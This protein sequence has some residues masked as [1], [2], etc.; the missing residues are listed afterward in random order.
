MPFV[1]I[2]R[3]L[4]LSVRCLEFEVVSTTNQLKTLLTQL[5][6]QILPKLRLLYSQVHHIQLLTLNYVYDL[7]SPTCPISIRNLVV[8]Y[9]S[10]SFNIILWMCSHK[11]F[12]WTI[13]LN[14]SKHPTFIHK[15]V[16][17]HTFTHIL[18]T[19]FTYHILKD[20]AFPKFLYE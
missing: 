6:F 4:I 8:S 5:A 20:I 2:S 1:N 19:I 13:S 16:T 18:Y 17:M 9:S 14:P 7:V 12:V 3:A 15:F 11:A 10:I